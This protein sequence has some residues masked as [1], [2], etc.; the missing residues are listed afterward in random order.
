MLG[1]KSGQLYH[2]IKNSKS[3]DDPQTENELKRP[4]LTML[5]GEGALKIV[6]YG[7]EE[8]YCATVKDWERVLGS[9]PVAS[10]HRR[11]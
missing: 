10:E 9:K 7:S 4:V 6:K 2:L 5:L 1:I 8:Y 3:A 11:Q